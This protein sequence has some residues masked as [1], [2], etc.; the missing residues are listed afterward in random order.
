M[1]QTMVTT[2]TTL[3]HIVIGCCCYVGSCFCVDVLSNTGWAS[4]LPII[5]FLRGD[6]GAVLARLGRQWKQDPR[7]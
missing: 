2:A 6:L 5:G 3:R 1:L 7:N 4:I